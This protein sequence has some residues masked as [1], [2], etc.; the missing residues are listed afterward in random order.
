[1]EAAKER[2]GRLDTIFAIRNRLVA[3]K[4]SLWVQMMRRLLTPLTVLLLVAPAAA[5]GLA[6]FL[7]PVAEH[8]GLAASRAQLSIEEARLANARDPFTLSVSAGYSRFSIDDSSLGWLPEE[9]KELF[10]PPRSASQ[11]SA[12]LSLRP[13]AFGDIRDLQDQ[14]ELQYGLALLGYRETLTSLQVNAVL[15]AYSLHLAEESLEVAA[16]GVELARRA[17]EAIRLSHA[18]GAANDRDLREAEAGTREALEL[19]SQAEAG[20]ELARLGLESLVGDSP[21]PAR[22]E[23]QLPL[24]S[25]E[26]ASVQRAR[27]Q[28]GLAAV[29]ARNARREVLPVVQTGYT[30][31]VSDNSSVGFS[32]ESRTLQPNLN[33][34]WQS[35]ERSF[36]E[37]LITGSFQIGLSASI[38]PAIG[39]ALEAARAQ[40]EAGGHALA[41]AQ[42]LAATEQAS[43]TAR[44]EEAQRGLDL[45]DL[46]FRNA[47]LSLQEADARE[48]LGLATALE[49]QQAV[50][51]LMRAELELKQARLTQLE[52]TLAFHEFLARP[53]T[54]VAQQP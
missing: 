50:L 20:V 51:G 19:H 31:H 45:K 4:G 25:G 22:E 54:E 5:Q 39:A 41:A 26:P 10:M 29:G 36:P 2:A 28:A 8:P 40:E 43:L 21:A 6:A 34:T 3:I 47:R 42:Q 53:L 15:A 1:M 35:M 32:L 52:R 13:F 9:L 44:L 24:P 30:H 12:D 23:L 49:T 18:N 11:I 16:A 46:L 37:N 14:A 48:K 17:E 38:S 33:W 7:E 27:L